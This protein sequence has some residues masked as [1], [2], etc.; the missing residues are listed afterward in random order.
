MMNVFNT[1]VLLSAIVVCNTFHAIYYAFVLIRLYS[2]VFS[3]QFT[4]WSWW[5]HDWFDSGAGKLSRI[6]TEIISR[7]VIDT[8]GDKGKYEMSTV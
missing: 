8:P 6:I 2:S 3:M 1:A 5:C 4:A 7:I